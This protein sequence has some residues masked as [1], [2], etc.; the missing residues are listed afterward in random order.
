MSEVRAPLTIL[1]FFNPECDACG[2]ITDQLVPV[3]NRVKNRGVTVYA[4]YLDRKT[5]VWENYIAEKKLDWINVY[6]PDGSEGIEA[7][8]DIYAIP[9]IY[10]L[11]AEKKIIAR[12][13]PVNA[14]EE[15]ILQ[16][17]R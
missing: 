14:L 11:D 13:V 6:D 8:Y 15:L 9:M 16:N 5:E 3:Y 10:L 17:L 12:D 2:P 4:A 1:Y 7:K